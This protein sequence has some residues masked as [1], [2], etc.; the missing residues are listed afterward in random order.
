MAL[1]RRPS[2]SE[3]STDGFKYCFTTRTGYWIMRRGGVIA[4]TG[5]CG[6]AAL[7]TDLRAHQ[8]PTN[9]KR[10]R[11]DVESTIPVG[12]HEH[13]DPVW[14]RWEE[15]KRVAEKLLANF[16]DLTPEVQDLAGKAQRQMGS[17]G[18]GNHFI[19]LCLDTEQH[20]WLMLHSG[21]RNIGKELAEIHIDRAMALT[22]NETL[23]DRSLAVFLAGTPEMAAYRRDLYWAQDYARVNRM[24]ML[25]LYLET[26]SKHLPK[27][28]ILRE[29]HCHHNYVAEETHYGEH[30]F[31]TR[32][33]A[34]RA[35]VG[36]MGIIP[37]AMGA[38]S[39]IVSGLGNPKSFESASHGAGRRMSRNA[40]LKRFTVRD[41]EESPKG[42]ECRKD[43]G[44]IDGIKGSYKDIERVMEYQRDLVKVEAELHAVMCVK[45]G[46]DNEKRKRAERRDALP[47]DPVEREYDARRDRKIQRTLKR[48][49]Y[50]S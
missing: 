45:G 41:M 19:E 29:V 39:F 4:V 2:S 42:V 33:G 6:M 15:T 37:G 20:V 18:S 9:L 27:F 49:A 30:V 38:K 50:R 40:A 10:L 13:T 11:L 1:Q 48:G 43:K 47:G 23:P 34:I 5:N 25:R 3:P 24:I 46:K 44:V 36:E 28:N 32:K 17:L 31:V 35:G 16:K 12:F 22:H 26:L 21:S 8:L 14:H 7:E